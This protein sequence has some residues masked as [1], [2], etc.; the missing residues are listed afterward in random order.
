MPIPLLGL[1]PAP[2]TVQR[3]SEIAQE[4]LLMLLPD[5]GQRGARDNAW[6]AVTGLSAAADSRRRLERMAGAP[7]D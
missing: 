3:S 2:P 4:A 7:H 1:L 6:R 5:G